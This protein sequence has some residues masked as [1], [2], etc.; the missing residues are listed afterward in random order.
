MDTFF[1]S[2]GPVSI[3]GSQ[4]QLQKNSGNGN[5]GNMYLYLHKESLLSLSAGYWRNSLD[6]KEAITG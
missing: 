1:W 3:Y 2:Q 6:E 4:A 5:V